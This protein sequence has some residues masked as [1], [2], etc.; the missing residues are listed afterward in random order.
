[1][2]NF[3]KKLKEIRISSQL[4]QKQ[5]ADKLG[6]SQNAVY[7]WENGLREPNLDMLEKISSVL[8]VNLYQLLGTDEIAQI[9]IREHPE[10]WGLPNN[11]IAA[12]FDGNE[13]TEDELEEIRQFAEFVKS[14]RKWN[15]NHEL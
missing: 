4:T 10:K 6:V 11:T 2:P 5:L 12:H 1:M 15:K 9:D 8:G 14:K 3:S 13:Y 7:L